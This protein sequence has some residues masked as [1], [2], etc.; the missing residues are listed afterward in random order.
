MEMGPN[1]ELAADG[2]IIYPNNAAIAYGYDVGGNL[3]TETLVQ[4]GAT[5][6]KTYTWTAGKMTN[7]S[8]WTKQP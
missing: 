6:V 4:Y 2:N 7:Q 3:I 1:G 5:Y 8:L